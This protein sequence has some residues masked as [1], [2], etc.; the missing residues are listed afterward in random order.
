MVVTS[1]PGQYCCPV[2]YAAAS[3]NDSG[4]EAKVKATKVE[5]TKLDGDV[6][7]WYC[8]VSDDGGR[9]EDCGSSGDGEALPPRASSDV[10]EPQQGEGVL[11]PPFEVE[12]L[13]K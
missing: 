7:I 3:A 6:Q 4:L 8:V 12:E 9:Q 5:E 1:E 2:C 11:T 10:E 13:D